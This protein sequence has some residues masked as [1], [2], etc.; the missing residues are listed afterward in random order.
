MLLDYLASRFYL[1]PENIAT[2]ALGYIL[3]TSKPA[4]EALGAF[5]GQIG[6]ALRAELRFETQA[7]S[8]QEANIPDVV[9]RDLDGKEPLIIEGKFWAGLTENQPVAYLRRLP[10]GA[11]GIVLFVAPELRL[12]LL[13]VELT[14]RTREALLP[15][16]KGAVPMS[17]RIGT[18]DHHLAVV[19]W[20][21]LL[22]ALSLRAAAGD[23]VQTVHDIEQLQGL[24]ERMDQE[25]FLPLRA[26]ETTNTEVARRVVDFSR[27]V[28]EICRKASAEGFATGVGGGTSG[29]GWYGHYF[30]LA[31]VQALFAFDAS[32]WAKYG[33]TPLWLN[34]WGRD[35]EVSQQVLDALAPLARDTPVRLI[36][37]DEGKGIAYGRPVVPILL[38]LGVVRDEVVEAALVQFRSIATLLRPLDMLS[39]LNPIVPSEPDEPPT[40]P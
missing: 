20:R 14:K 1:Q 9:G 13:W 35:W 17:M 4:R 11:S 24:C 8:E 40:A 38:S 29:L 34:L 28:D 30:R 26:E 31:G 25:G 7:R 5:I 19:S 15:C 16:G 33:L 10:E 36:R 32:K 37:L 6:P 21:S 12:S 3:R 39:G 23:E 27:L 18:H 2:E 22:A